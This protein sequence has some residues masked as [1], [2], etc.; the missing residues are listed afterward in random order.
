[1][2]QT[3]FVWVLPWKAFCNFLLVLSATFEE[4]LLAVIV[5]A[6][7]LVLNTIKLVYF[8]ESI[9]TV[10]IILVKVVAISCLDHFALTNVEMELFIKTSYN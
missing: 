7:V 2:E 4:H 6:N 1:M 8:H 5:R 9:Q 10:N 3:Y